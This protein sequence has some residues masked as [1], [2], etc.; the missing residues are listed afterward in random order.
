MSLRRKNL[1]SSCPIFVDTKDTKLRIKSHKEVWDNVRIVHISLQLF[2]DQ[3]QLFEV[4][5]WKIMAQINKQTLGF[6]KI[7]S[8]LLYE[9]QCYGMLCLLIIKAKATRQAPNF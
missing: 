6:I 7:H 5:D 4:T 8:F 1:D 9:V 2:Q 3:V